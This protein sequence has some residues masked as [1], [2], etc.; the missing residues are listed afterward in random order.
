M[1]QPA[2]FAAAAYAESSLSGLQNWRLSPFFRILLV[3][4]CKSSRLLRTTAPLRFAS[5]GHG[6]VSRRERGVPILN[7]SER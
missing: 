7:F 5:R 4:T 2:N 3:P 6:T 1:G